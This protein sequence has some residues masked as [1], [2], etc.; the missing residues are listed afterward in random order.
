M[1]PPPSQAVFP[2]RCFSLQQRPLLCGHRFSLALPRPS[3]YTTA[4]GLFTPVARPLFWTP[5]AGPC[6]LCPPHLRLR[7]VHSTLTLIRLQNLPQ[8]HNAATTPLRFSPK[9][10][11]GQ[12]SASPHDPEKGKSK[13]STDPGFG[14]RLPSPPRV[15][16]PVCACF[17]FGK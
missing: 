13:Y 10:L 15:T 3:S 17:L 6:P 14:V 12:N 5:L 7:P 4:W 9:P 8:P 16:S 1:A 2:G 11:R